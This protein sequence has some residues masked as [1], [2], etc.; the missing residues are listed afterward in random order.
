M[1]V[2]LCYATFS[3]FNTV[4]GWQHNVDQTDLLEFGEYFSRFVTQ[5][6]LTAPL[7]EGFPE[8]IG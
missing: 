6:R 4:F 1:F 7:C 2:R 3:D 5:P 8:Y